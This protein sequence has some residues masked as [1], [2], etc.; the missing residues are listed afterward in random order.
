LARASKIEGEGEREH[1]RKSIKRTMRAITALCIAG[2]IVFAASNLERTPITNRW[3]VVSSNF[4][5]DISAAARAGSGQLLEQYKG[6][7][8]GVDDPLYLRVHSV[9]SRLLD[10]ACSQEQL[11][12]LG[13]PSTGHICKRASK[14]QWRLAVIDRKDVEN[15]CVTA[16]GTILFFTG[17]LPLLADDKNGNLHILLL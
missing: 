13:V 12:S 14:V 1:E 15:A 2:A 3:R 16:D 6:H 17:L 7:I 10:A 8:L 11:E 5:E 4:E 9:V